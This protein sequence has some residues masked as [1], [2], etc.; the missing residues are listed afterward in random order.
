MPF[1]IDSSGVQIDGMVFTGTRLS[2]PALSAQ[3]CTSD[4]D[5]PMAGGLRINGSKNMITRSVFR[6]MACY[7]AIEYGRGEDVVIRRNL[8]SSNGTHNI[9]LHWADGLTIHSGTR[10]QVTDNRFRGNGDV[11]LILGGC[12]D[13]IV[14]N[15]RFYHSGS[16]GGGSF[17]ELM[18]HAWPKA[19]SGDFIVTRVTGN[20]INCGPQQRCGFGIM[21]GAAPWYDT[22]TFGGTVSGNTIRGVMLALNVDELTGLMTIENNDLNLSSGTSPSMCGPHRIRAVSTHS[23]SYP[24]DL[25]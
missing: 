23:G 5:K 22:P 17:A 3:R 6:D 15:N 11:Q 4:K 8:F 19:T 9:Q 13:C 18:L 21:I 16:A 24:H 20:Y 14:T 12:A 10:F 2:H 25:K 1:D 7:T